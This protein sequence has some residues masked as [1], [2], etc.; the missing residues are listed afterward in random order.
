MKTLKMAVIF[1]LLLGCYTMAPAAEQAS[2]RW[3]NLM[4]V[5]YK[6]TWYPKENLNSLLQQ[7]A[8]EYGQSLDDYRR[9]MINDLTEGAG[10]A[11]GLLDAKLFVSGKPWKMYYRLGIAQF[12]LF[13]ADDN[14]TQLENAITVMDILSGKKEL[15]DVAFW[16]YMLQAYQGLIK[17]DRDAFVASVFQVWQNAVLKLE[18]DNIFM[19]ATFTKTELVKNL[20]FLYENM[21]HLII[22]RGI[23]EK[24]IPDLYPLGL[25]IMSIRDRLSIENGYKNI[26]DPIAERMH[27]L[28]S[29]NSNLN[30][31]AAFV[32]ATAN[33]Y[34]FEDEQ[35][36]S[37]VVPKYNLT[38]TYI[39][40]AYTWA[41][42]L[43]GKAAILTQNMGFKSY[44]L[45]RLID[46]DKLLISKPV[47][48]EIPGE[49]TLLVEEAIALYDQLAKP[50]VRKGE[51][52]TE[53]FQKK[54]SYI[55]A[56]HQLWD[57]TG[58]LMLMLS[59]YY[60]E[61]GDGAENQYTTESSLQ[62]YF[63]LFRRYASKQSEIVP[64][65]AFFM[66]YYAANEMAA[67]YR[68][69]SRYSTTIDIN[70]LAFAY[71]LQAVEL[72]PLD[73]TGILHLAYQANQEGRH[74]LYLQYVIPLA[75]RLNLS[76][77]SGI[78]LDHHATEYRA[79][80]AGITGFIPEIIENAPL[81]INFIQKSKGKESQEE[82]FN[83]AIVMAKVLSAYKAAPV[84][85]NIND[86]L[87]AIAEHDFSDKSKPVKMMLKNILPG[88]ATD[89]V[90]SIP[91]LDTRYRISALQNALF[92]SPKHAVHSYLRGLYYE[93]PDE[94]H[95]YRG[96]MES[97]LKKTQ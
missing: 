55:A 34:D 90:D 20:P 23:L 64:D 2:A 59:A 13:L 40:L 1:L 68:K 66:A 83:K 29:D 5:A 81:L 50:W 14:E 60:E 88:E 39:D 91:E 22:T 24:T 9:V 86:I 17:K 7:K 82:L 85:V 93:T 94:N 54:S 25:I 19:G 79:S 8:G 26:V 18:V 65:S 48:N 21:A 36:A 57:A 45:R 77:A 67:V 78:W 30:F 75:A 52:K 41:D 10:S 42:T 46:K 58:K 72:F 56:M 31:A 97:A 92:G 76:K 4:D 95:M 89:F 71:Q 53:G 11:S 47:F 96:L 16:Q 38:R 73:I 62:K 44:I 15:P 43:K 35:S 3:G 37:Q 6:F 27:G 32:E 87:L 12:C 69:A 61:A 51:F 70:N 84:A 74:N 80:I 49:S 63:S 33:Q 28:K